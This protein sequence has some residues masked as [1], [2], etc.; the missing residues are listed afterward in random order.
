MNNDLL[1]LFRIYSK[2]GLRY[3]M[4]ESFARHAVWQKGHTGLGLVCLKEQDS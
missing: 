3:S 4:G 1:H 2:I